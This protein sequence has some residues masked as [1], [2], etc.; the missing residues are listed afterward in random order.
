MGI[1]C[2]DW[3]VR[4]DL[5][6]PAPDFFVE[7]W[8]PQPHGQHDGHEQGPERC[9]VFKSEHELDSQHAS[10]PSTHF[11][12]QRLCPQGGRLSTL[13]FGSRLWLSALGP[14]LGSW[15]PKPQPRAESRKPKAESRKPKAQS[16]KPK[17]ES[18]QACRLGWVTGFEPATSGATVRRSTAELY[19]PCV[20]CGMRSAA[21]Q[22]CLAAMH[23]AQP[24]R[25]ASPQ[26]T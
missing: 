4:T 26:C 25:A 11:G 12:R 7:I 24:F 14:D 9:G 6:F 15:L 13:A 16:R 1:A 20:V 3:C 18:R 19:P 2:A 21:L 22:G 23:R 5:R 17:A 8:D 10:P